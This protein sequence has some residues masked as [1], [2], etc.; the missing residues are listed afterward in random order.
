MNIAILFFILCDRLTMKTQIMIRISIPIL[1]GILFLSS[2]SSK[3]EGI[4][5]NEKSPADW[6]NP[7]VF[8]I[9][10][11]NPRA[12]FVPYLNKQSAA[13]E[14]L[15][16]SQL[17]LSLN[18]VWDFH[19]SKTP[20]ERPFYFFKNDYNIKD[21]DKIEVP[22]NWEV[23]GYDIPIYTNVKYPHEN[24][25]PSIQKHYNP[26][27]SYKRVFKIPEAWVDKEIFLHFGA[28]SSAFYVWVNEQKV[29]YSEDSKTPAEFNITPYLN[30]GKNTIAVEVYRWSDASYLEDQ[31]FWS[32]SGITRDVYLL[33]RNQQHIRDFRVIADLDK[34]YKTGLFDLFLEL[35][36]ITEIDV[37]AELFFN[38]EEVKTFSSTE[39]TLVHFEITLEN[40][41]TWTAETPH[42]YELYITLKKENEILE[43]IR[44]DVGF[45]KIEIADNKVL[46]NGE[47]I[48]FKGVN[49]H[50]HN[51]LTGHVQDR[52]T[53]LKDIELLRRYNLN[54]VRTSHYPQPEEW[55]KLCNKYGIYLVDEANI[56]SHEMGATHQD[57]FDKSKHIAYQP[58]WA[59]AHSYRIRNMYERDKN[60]PSV[61]IWSMGNECGNGQVFFD[62]Y[63]YLKSTDSTRLVQFEQAESPLNSDI[64]CPMYMRPGAIEEYAQNNP[65]QP[66]VLCE[67]AHAMGN[68]VGNLQDYWD[69]IEKYECLQGGFIWD[70]V[71]QGL[72]TKNEENEE[73]WAYGGDFGPKDVPSDGAFCLNGLVNPDRGVKPHLNEVKKVYQNIGFETRDMLEGVFVIKNKFAFTNLNLFDFSYEIIANGKMIE[74]GEIKDVNAEPNT[75]VPIAIDY[76]MKAQKGVEY[77]INLYAKQRVAER[78]IPEGHILAYEQFIFPYI[79]N[80]ETLNTSDG[81]SVKIKADN[82]VFENGKTA[83]SGKVEISNDKLSANF[84]ADNG[85][86]LS[87]KSNGREVLNEFTP[88]FWRAPIDNDLG[89]D[90]HKRAKVWRK[91]GERKTLISSVLTQTADAASIEFRYDINDFENKAIAQL[92]LNYEVLKNGDIRVSN[93]FKIKDD[94]QAEIPRFGNN[95]VM[96]VEFENITWYGRGPHESYWDRKSS[97]LIGLYS[98]KIADQYWAYI[99]P[100]ENGN[101]TDMRWMAISDNEGHGLMFIGDPTIDGGAHHNI[102][103]DFES[104]ERTDGRQIEG[105]DVVNRH[106]TDVKPRQLTSVNVD[107]K[108]MGLGGNTS[109]GAW[110]H[111]AYRLT[112]KAY[113][114]HYTIRL[115]EKGEDPS[116]LY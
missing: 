69:I 72:L 80:K 52:E 58:E 73:F 14:E 115:I 34:T 41:N 97:A 75:A 112:K 74:E 99:R 33:A 1:L 55:Y 31:D 49:L 43:V 103:E 6:E 60:Q 66:L 20:P 28:V 48:Y 91:A 3:Y 88:N 16:S 70:W 51:E 50:E 18:G 104:M 106:T 27:G 83:V 76:K 10:K 110:T 56:E 102:M 114:Y 15:F 81:E 86:L 93:D 44:Q 47:Y 59:P 105:V 42:L 89:N 17:V 40:V 26:V 12:S 78:M 109:W 22:S 38:G 4:S 63:D 46:L 30:N 2:C 111:E 61:L 57:P 98:G 39:T 113:S 8:Q 92:T 94:N 100:Q 96:P 35:A 65:K 54:A 64:F 67:Y 32:L 107:Y 79:T 85:T 108:Q 23:K 71:D 19:L 45:R 7:E 82:I 25:P 84:D 101:K 87:L 77:F 9:N 21:W 24:T 53:M 116:E 37:H 90:M 36:S 95:L 68:S 13:K 11:E 5:Y 62:E 29:G